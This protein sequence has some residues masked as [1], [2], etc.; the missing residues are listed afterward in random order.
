M[1]KVVRNEVILKFSPTDRVKEIWVK[2]DQ[3]IIQ[4]TYNTG[5]PD[6]YETIEIPK[7]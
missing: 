1:E 7:S 4:I 2:K 3:G 5:G 6:F